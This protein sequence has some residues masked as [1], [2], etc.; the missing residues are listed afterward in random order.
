MGARNRPFS[1]KRGISLI[2]LFQIELTLSEELW[3]YRKLS[4][5]IWGISLSGASS[6][7]PVPVLGVRLMSNRTGCFSHPCKEQVH[8]MTFEVWP[9]H[10]ACLTGDPAQGFGLAHESFLL[11]PNF[12]VSAFSD[13]QLPEICTPSDHPWSPSSIPISVRLTRA[14]YRV[15]ASFR[16]F[17]A[18]FVLTLRQLKTA[19]PAQS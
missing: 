18:S 9:R 12:K 1:A 7:S 15:S 19:E 16:P 10:F 3:A 8:A 4:G 11:N 5:L 2:K 17:S 6:Y 14:H 13:Q